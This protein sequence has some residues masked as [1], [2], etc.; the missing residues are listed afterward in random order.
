MATVTFVE[1]TA[2]GER[3]EGRAVELAAERVTVEELIRRRVFLSSAEDPARR[4]A[5][6][7]TQAPAEPPEARAE[8]AL[9]AFAGNGLLVLVGDRQV[10][11]PDE[12]I[13]LSAGAEV[14]FL[15]LVPLVGG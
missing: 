15:R 10:T 3:G 14:T 2:S 7:S 6:R 8:A 13:E 9:G 11:E 4:T 1:E 5:G 12:E